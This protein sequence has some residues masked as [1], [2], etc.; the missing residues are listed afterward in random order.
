IGAMI[1]P[2]FGGLFVSYWTWRGIFFVNVPIGIAIVV[3][4]LRYIPR[5]RPGAD[6][7]RLVMD[8][9]GLALLGAG[10]LAGMLG[11]SY[12]GETDTRIA[13]PAF[14]I[15]AG[16]SIAAIWMVVR[17]IRRSPHPFIAP[18]LIHGPGFGSVNLV[19]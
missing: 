16:I 5:D 10:I 13:S 12:L 1:G 6:S 2:I 8:A 18:R 4:A 15:P 11:V 17:H 14:V 9:A 19:N 3:L 7:T